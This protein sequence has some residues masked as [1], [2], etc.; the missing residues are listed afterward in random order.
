MDIA[1]PPELLVLPERYWALFDRV[2]AQF[3]GDERVRAMW[4]HGAI[5]RGQADPGSDLDVSVAVRDEDFEEF[6]GE[7][8]EWLAAITPTLTA[9]PIAPG[10]FYALTPTC[11]RL[12]VISQRV[13]DLPGTTMTRRIKVFDRDGLTALIPAPA[14]PLPDPAKISYLIEETLRQAANFPTVIVR[15]DWLLGVIAVQQVQ[16]FL[17]ELFAESNK[18]A[19][20]TGPKQWSFKLTPRQRDVLARLPVASATEQSVL[21][22]RDAALAAFLAE[23]PPIAQRSAV[24]WPAELER[25]V[26]DFLASEG[27]PLPEPR[28][29]GNEQADR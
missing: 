24:P 10:S 29:G 17:Y 1:R 18:P 16:L 27:C 8:R 13:S 22:A 5:G 12:D 11:E 26:R 25:A 7:W 23:A 14:D 19:P 20:P 6:A 2:G 21:N 4:L 3:A 9:R 28:L 15:D